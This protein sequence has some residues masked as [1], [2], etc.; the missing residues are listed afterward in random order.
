MDIEE[1]CT[2]AGY[3]LMSRAC[4]LE[5]LFRCISH[6]NAVSTIHQLDAVKLFMRNEGCRVLVLMHLIRLAHAGIS[7]DCPVGSVL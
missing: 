2:G 7:H 3:I 5:A 1:T 4:L 6:S